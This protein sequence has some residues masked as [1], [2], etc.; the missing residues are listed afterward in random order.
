VSESFPDIRF[1]GQLRPSQ[2][3][4]VE[5]VRDQLSAGDRKFH[6]V[7]PPGSGKTVTGLF[8][9]AEVLRRPALVLS[10]NS[11]IQSQWAAR[12]DLFGVNGADIP[13]DLISTDPKDP[14]LITSLTYQ[15]VTLPSRNEVMLNDFAERMWIDSLI[16]KDEAKDPTEAL[17]WINDLKERNPDYHNKRL[18]YYRKQKRDEI[19]QA[20]ELSGLLHE[21]SME[22]LGLLKERGIGMLILDEC[23]HLLSHW[24]RV[25]AVTQQFLDDPIIVGLTATPPDDM[26]KDTVDSKRYREY[27]GPVDYEVPVPAVVKDG[28]LAPYQD[29]AYL[30]RPTA[31]ELRYVA[32][33]SDQF[34][35]LVHDLCN[36]P[37][38]EEGKPIRE[39]LDQYVQRILSTLKLPT[40]KA[41]NWLDFQKRASSFA[42]SS[43][44]LLKE[45]GKTVPPGV[46]EF[47]G[48]GND[49]EDPAKKIL[50]MESIVPVISW[51]LR[52]ALRGSADKEHHALAEKAISR[53]RILG[54]QIT[55]TGFQ[56]CASPVSRILMYSKA[57]AKAVIS[58][59]KRE[60][61]V[62]EDTI[63]A[64]VICDY[65]RTSA[66]TSEISHLLDDEA[67]GAVAAFR[68]LLNDEE[69]DAL[70][71]ILLTGSTILIDD[72]LKDLIEYECLKWLKENK[73]KVTL[74]WAEDAGFHVLKG[75]G[76]DWAPR[77]YVQMFTELFQ[78][79]ITRC[80][81]GTRGLLGE[82]WDAN[83][84]NVLIDLTSVT[85][86]MSVNQLRG[87]SFRLDSN[88]PHK[89]ANN[90]DVVCIAPEFTKGMDDYKRFKDKHKRLYGVT[91]DGAIE[92]GVGHVHASFMGLR[93]DDVEESMVNLNRD[94]LD[95]VGLRSQFYELWKIGKPYHPEPIKAV[96]IKSSRKGSD[97]GGF[98][99]GRMGD[100]EWTETTLTEVIAK[101]IIRS[102]FEAELIDASSWHELFQKLHVSERNGGYIRVFLEKADEKASAILSESLAQ[103]FGPIEDAR[104]LIERGVDFEYQESRFQETWVEQ[105]LPNFLS[106]FI[107]LKTMKTKRRFEVVRVHAVPKA[108]ATKKETALIFEKYWNKLVSPG[109]VLYRQNSQ[110]QALMDKATEDGLIVNDA[111]HEKE[112]FM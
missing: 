106:D 38:N 92:K 72:D 105:R 53:L 15:S 66:V 108:L 49:E 2:K 80:L 36:P 39:P 20:G 76:K 79:G 11:A 41:D 84:I 44:Y 86:S 24:G 98:P 8:L 42:W 81:V 17:V 4:V 75:K 6:V 73:K 83:K 16:N 57:K 27:F 51:Y 26:H 109:E 107:I 43:R 22:T 3:D 12:T 60:K 21:S 54:V 9:W 46:P 93:I 1:R 59:L 85:T 13:S 56:N 10:P 95:R 68:E 5:I 94:M 52:H 104:Y 62:L 100:P 48:I 34:T 31:E 58:I 103:V 7:A 18:S 87:R 25:L 101:A 77:V 33:T 78:R 61:E 23:H 74:E 99:P 111:V 89:I 110:T 67:G 14:S 45:L 88:V 102:L 50:D 112:V 32:R 30:I 63:R 37:M 19:I 91:D 65:E 71:P 35:E 29:L 28:F 97:R 69:T 47:P 90:W 70:D 55:E 82:G 96:E 40:G 64:V